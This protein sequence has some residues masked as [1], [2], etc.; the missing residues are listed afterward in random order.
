MTDSMDRR[1]RNEIKK[2]EYSKLKLSYELAENGKTDNDTYHKIQ[3]ALEDAGFIFSVKNDKLTIEVL[4]SKYVRNRF[5]NAGRKPK[6]V[7]RKDNFLSYRYSDIVCMMQTM[8]D[9]EIYGKIGMPSAT[10]YR[11]KKELMSSNYYKQLDKNK[12]TDISYLKTVSGD[13]VF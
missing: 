2:K 9:K 10:Y 11:H 13:N 4:E 7:Q 8:T 6:S 5:R 1:S 3:A 12:L